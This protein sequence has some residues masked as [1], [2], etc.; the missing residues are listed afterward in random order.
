MRNIFIP[1]DLS[2]ERE[3]TGNGLRLAS[4]R[5]K[6]EGNAIT[7]FL[8]GDAVGAGAAEQV[9][10]NGDCDLERMRT[11]PA[12]EGVKTG[13]RGTCIDARRIE[14]GSLVER[15]KRSSIA[16]LNS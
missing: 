3:R 10:P 12:T 2:Y 8:M 14:A 15:G 6:I 5:A 1:D 16:E 13:L 4:S 7:A 11:G 9:P